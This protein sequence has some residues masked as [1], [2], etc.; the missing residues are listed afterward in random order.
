MRTIKKRRPPQ[1][2]TNWRGPRMKKNKLPGMECTYEEMRRDPCVADVEDSLFD[3]QG[4]I[5]A[6]TGLRLRLVKEDQ[7]TGTARDV[8]FHI[9]HFIPRDFCKREYN[10]Y[11]RGADYRNMA[12]CWP[13]PNVHFEPG[14]GA[15]KKDNWPSPDEEYLF[16]S[17]LDPTCT[18]RFV[19]DHE[20]KIAPSNLSDNA[21]KE[22]ICRLGLNNGE[23]PELRKQTT[24]GA[25]SPGGNWLTLDQ[26]K[27]L[28]ETIENDARSLDK[29]KAV[30]LMPFWFA[31]RLALKRRIRKLGGKC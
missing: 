3:E 1:S 28:L 24:I 18:D 14:Y 17:P 5:C 9:E 19:F 23:L 21:A 12:A 15:R 16:V 20:G 4:G 31:V 29:G 11:G 22:T 2:L 27:R 7:H 26:S 10:N 30:K 13:R 8:D 25:L 6:Y